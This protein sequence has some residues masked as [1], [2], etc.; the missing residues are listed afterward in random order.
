MGYVWSLAENAALPTGLEITAGGRIQ[1][2]P[3]EAG[4]TEVEVR[5]TD[6]NGRDT[7]TTFGMRVC[8]SPLGLEVGDVMTV[9]PEELEPCGFLLARRRCRGLLP[10]DLRGSRRRGSGELA[11][12]PLDGTACGTDRGAASRHRRTPSAAAGRSGP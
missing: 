7:T 6:S 8:D 1:G 5:V 4:V 2:T 10:G 3:E 12:E 11:N 9:D